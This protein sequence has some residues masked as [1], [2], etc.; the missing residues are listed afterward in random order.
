MATAGQVMLSI[1]GS[2]VRPRVT[3]TL[4]CES[5]EL[6]T[7]ASEMLRI[8]QAACAVFQ[9]RKSRVLNRRKR[10]N[11]QVHAGAAGCGVQAQASLRIGVVGNVGAAIGFHAGV[12]IARGHHGE[13]SRG[14]KGPEPDA[15]G[16]RECLF[17]LLAEV[18]AGVVA[19]VRR[20]EHHHKARRSRR[21]LSECYRAGGDGEEGADGSA[22]G[23]KCR[24][25]GS[26]PLER[27]SLRMTV[28]SWK[29]RSFDF[30]APS[31]RSLRTTGQ[32]LS[33]GHRWPGR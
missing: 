6:I 19:A 4:A 13:A 3:G 23:R 11:K 8:T 24:S 25:F 17:S 27:D 28:D 31:A 33:R 26:F 12:G 21:S 15:E 7:P 5:A 9:G 14:E 29:C 22:K 20:V 18:S 2:A 16:Q 30:L 32:D 1:A 10:R